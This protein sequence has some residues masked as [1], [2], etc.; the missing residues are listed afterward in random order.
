ME[1]PICCGSQLYDKH[2][3]NYNVTR[4][5]LLALVTFVK[6]FRQYSLGRPFTIRTDHA[7]FQWLRRTPEPIGQ[8]A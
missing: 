7:A 2:Q 8:Q 3:Q 4:K 1:R 6:K 5:Q